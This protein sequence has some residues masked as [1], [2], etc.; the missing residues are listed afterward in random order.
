MRPWIGTG[1]LRAVLVPAHFEA[2]ARVVSR[3]DTSSDL[4]TQKGHRS[5]RDAGG[6]LAPLPIPSPGVPQP[7][8]SGPQE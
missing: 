2:N 6:G 3:A 4:G 5:L 8:P 7:T 1:F